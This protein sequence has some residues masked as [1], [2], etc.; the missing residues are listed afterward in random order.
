M[1][2]YLKIFS[3]GLIELFSYIFLRDQM[4]YIGLSN[5]FVFWTLISLT[6]PIYIFFI[7]S[8]PLYNRAVMHYQN[9]NLVKNPEDVAHS[10]GIVNTFSKAIKIK[11]IIVNKK[12]YI[13]FLIYFFINGIA[14][15]IT[16]R[17]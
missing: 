10:V 7:K 12:V 6:L 11:Q 8:T 13:I 9:V 15:L 17:A 1:K 16:L 5:F 3:F 2:R 4:K 14:Y